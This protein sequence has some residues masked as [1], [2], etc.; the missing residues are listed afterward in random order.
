MTA[1]PAAAR[2]PRTILVAHPSADLYG[3]DRVLLESVSG[4]VEAGWRVAVTTPEPGPLVAL[5]EAR[6]A[7]VVHCPSPVLR[8][9]MLRPR[10]LVELVRQGLVGLRRG[11]RLVSSLRPDAVYVNTVTVPLWLVVARLRRV[12]VLC[13]VHEAEGSAPRV[14]RALLAAPLLL[15]NAVIANS[16]FSIDVLRTSSRRLAARTELVYNGVPGPASRVLA[17]ETLTP[18]VRLVYLGRLSPRK[19]VSVA[20]SALAALDALGVR[21][22]L[23]LV[24]AV[25]PGYEWYEQELRDQVARLDLA[26]RVTFHG[27]LDDV[28]TLVAACDVLVVPSVVDEPFGNTAVEG[29]LSARPVVASATSGLLEATAGYRSAQTVTPDDP[30]ALARAVADVVQQWPAYRANAWDDASTATTRH[31]PQGYRSAVSKAV[32]RMVDA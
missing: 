16:Q 13:H 6:G 7:R 8:K 5:L 25:F 32:E 19:G 22:T 23:D 15:A 24:G 3:S 20:V 29:V 18:P 31:A 12:P 10:G 27:F 17:R 4:L 28:W 30:D 2:R 11:S 21:A 9:A 26:D 1:K 14:V